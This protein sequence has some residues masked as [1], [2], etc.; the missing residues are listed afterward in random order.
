MKRLRHI[1]RNA[2]RHSGL[3]LALVTATIACADTVELRDGTLLQ[4]TFLGGTQ[5]SVRFQTQTELKVIPVTDILAV[6]F[7]RPTAPPAATTAPGTPAVATVPA[8]VPAAPP[9][10]TTPG[11][12][13]A[14]APV[15]P[16]AATAA[17]V[18]PP[19]PS[20]PAGTK[21][22]VRI[23]EAVDS[24]V[25]KAGTRFT[26]VVAADVHA[27]DAVP[28]PAGTPVAGELA[29]GTAPQPAL[30]LVLTGITLQEQVRP[31]VTADVVA[32]S[33]PLTKKNVG[34]AA[35]GAVFGAVGGGGSQGAAKAAGAAAL[36][37]VAVKGDTVN[38]PAG[39]VLEFQ[40][41]NAFTP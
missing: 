24:A 1:T 22:Q 19:K 39:A 15:T 25:N 16:P 9:G 10:A 35:I 17:V 23:N 3:W 41:K 30:Q 14:T 18:P 28:V 32:V 38:V 26:G 6:T 29:A 27:G 21:L 34:G 12:T 7:D 2:V 4:G 40:L 5:T 11:P 8:T 20:L 37:T 33:A 13:P 36:A 31:V